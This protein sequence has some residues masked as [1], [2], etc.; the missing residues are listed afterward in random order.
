MPR[1][2]LICVFLL[3]S[4]AGCGQAT[5]ASE[6]DPAARALV[7]LRSC[8]SG[9]YRRLGSDRIAYAAIVRG[10]ATVVRKP[11][12]TALAGFAEENVNG[13]A[14]VFSVL[15]A[16]VDRRCRPTLYRV[17]V[18]LRPNGVTGWVAPAAVA[19]ARV[20]TRIVVELSER[21]LT[22]YRN[23]KPVLTSR[24]AIGAPSTPTPTGRYYVNQ[25]LIPTD[26][27]GP[28][29]PGAVGISAFSDVLTGW[30]QGGPIAIHG[31]NAPWSIGEAVSNGCLRVPNDVLRH[32]FKQALAGTPVLIRS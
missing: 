17:Q 27:S 9:S 5:V 4:A 6:P 11:G 7:E 26:P 10:H 28:F 12:G 18:P 8:A 2:P 13:V 15:G 3:L 16:R 25:R 32:V 20:R 24:V 21:R 14:T 29:G 30:T 31:T 1:A 22:L 19:V 23:G